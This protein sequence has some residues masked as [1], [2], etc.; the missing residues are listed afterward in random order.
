M[1]CQNLAPNLPI[2]GL[3]SLPSNL[4]SL[5]NL[6]AILNR[7]SLTSIVSNGLPM[8][9]GASSASQPPINSQPMHGSN[10]NMI[11]ILNNANK[12]F[13]LGG[14]ETPANGTGGLSMTGAEPNPNYLT[15]NGENSMPQH[16][17]VLI[18]GMQRFSLN[19]IKSLHNFEPRDTST[20]I[21]LSPFS[22]WSTLIVTYMGAKG[23]TER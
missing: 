23:E 13:D 20:G 19:L 16:W 10:R 1:E 22:I 15:F 6:P 11:N 17:R 18:S 12:A 3:A 21:I 2:S 14:D 7:P 8:A 5:S 4:P 9:S